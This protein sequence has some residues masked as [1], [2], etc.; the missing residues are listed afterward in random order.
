MASV[1]SANLQAGLGGH[2]GSARENSSSTSVPRPPTGSSGQSVD[3]QPSNYQAPNVDDVREGPRTFNPAENAQQPRFNGRS[4]FQPSNAIYR[5]AGEAPEGA[6]PMDMD[7]ASLPDTDGDQMSVDTPEEEQERLNLLAEGRA[8]ALESIGLPD[9]V[10]YQ[11]RR[12]SRS[13]KRL[14]E[15]GTR[16][17][18]ADKQMELV[19]KIN[20]GIQRLD[21]NPDYLYPADS[22]RSHIEIMVGLIDKVENSRDETTTNLAFK[23]L[24]EEVQ[25][26][27]MD[28]ERRNLEWQSL[29]TDSVQ[30]YIFKAMEKSPL[31]GRFESQQTVDTVRKTLQP[32][33]LQGLILQKATNIV[34][35]IFLGSFNAADLEELKSVQSELVESNGDSDTELSD[36]EIPVEDIKLILAKIQERPA[37]KERLL[38]NLHKRFLIQGLPENWIPYGPAFD[39]QEL[40]WEVI[41]MRANG[42]VFDVVKGSAEGREIVLNTGAAAGV[43]PAAAVA[44][45]ATA[46]AATA[47]AGT[48]PATPPRT[49]PSASNTVQ[50]DTLPQLVDVTIEIPTFASGITAYGTL[51]GAM[52]AGF[53]YRMILNTG[54]DKH[55]L[56]EMFKGSDFGRG[57]GAEYYN[58]KPLP[59]LHRPIKE[60]KGNQILQVRNMAQV[61]RDPKSTST[62]RPVTY[63][64]VRW[65][66]EATFG[67]PRDE[68]ITQSDYITLCGAKDWTN[69]MVTLNARNEVNK[70]AFKA[71]KEQGKHPDDNRQL[72]P[73]DVQ[74]TPWLCPESLSMRAATGND[75]THLGPSAP[76]TQENGASSV[77]P[78]IADGYQLNA[79]QA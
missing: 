26:R 23:Q 40:Y 56:Y 51:V 63:V 66:P 11:H 9:W 15:L 73:D 44:P 61:P 58:Q 69:K 33:E 10:K 17:R 3:P 5:A 1:A 12:A 37:D 27:T 22:V 64:L 47:P 42:L 4:H 53:G 54:T 32:T 79:P 75:P 34:Q 67:G 71:F 49:S 57:M 31:D 50:S 36:H 55:P 48:A 62:R 59:T 13:L 68:F 2:D 60:R 29:L 8:N 46:P 74:K 77:V 19:A 43:A 35:K 24:L 14:W 41:R 39:T 20:D 52:K 6:Y 28:Y 18:H 45:A 65:K 38:A 25:V 76:S 7:K 21:Q 16:G 30:H 70:K 78:P 72:T